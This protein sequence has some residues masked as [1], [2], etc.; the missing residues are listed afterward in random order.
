M[1]ND[2]RPAAVTGVSRSA[3]A[4]FLRARRHL[5]RPED[6]GLAAGGRRRVAGLRRDEVARLAG[7]SNQYYQRLEQGRDRHPSEQVLVGLT[8][9]LRLESD[10]ARH[11]RELASYQPAR[12]YS[13]NTPTPH[14]DPMIKQ[15][16]DSWPMTPA[17]VYLNRTLTVGAANLLAIALSPLFGPG[18]NSLR[19]LFFE[20]Q[21]REFYRNWEQLTVATVPYL[22]S[23]LG[24]NRADAEL[25]RLIGDLSAESERFRALWQRHDVEYNPRG[26]MLIRHPEVGDLDLRYQQLVMPN[27]GQ[28]LIPYWAEPGSISEQRLRLLA[29]V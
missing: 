1:G 19:T 11:L 9:A 17:Q 13:P 23:L 24:A 22:R 12:R 26:V 14:V 3:L 28:L 10:A 25:I 2:D 27:T 7:I 15:L 4:E 29:G 8:R 16:I 20:P 6:V 18:H 5:V 21:M